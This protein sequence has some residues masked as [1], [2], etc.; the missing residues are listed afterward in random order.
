MSLEIE[1]KPLLA[2]IF[3]K[4]GF[5]IDT[6]LTNARFIIKWSKN[7]L[8][9]DQ[10]K[11]NI[12]TIFGR[13]IKLNIFSFRYLAYY[14]SSNSNEKALLASIDTLQIIF[15]ITPLEGE[16]SYSFT[17]YDLEQSQYNVAAFGSQ[18]SVRGK[19]NDAKF[20]QRI[21]AH[22]QMGILL[23]EFAI[24]RKDTDFSIAKSKAGFPLSDLAEFLKAEIKG[25]IRP[26]IIDAYENMPFARLTNESSFMGSKNAF[27]G[28]DADIELLAQAILD[29]AVG[30][31]QEG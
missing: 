8:I 31:T 15:E 7:P 19:R 14:R 12:N 10:I 11:K 28:S 4:E 22:V 5:T 1:Q 26:H 23:K 17:D 18:R 3:T 13:L 27:T 16:D 20:A 21:Q 29:N 25:E 9:T 6:R 2:S 24:S 30:Y